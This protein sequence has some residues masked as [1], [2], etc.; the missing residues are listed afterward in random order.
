MNLQCIFLFTSNRYNE[1]KKWTDRAKLFCNGQLCVKK[2]FIPI[3]RN[4]YHW[5]CVCV[6]I[7]ENSIYLYDSL[8][9]H[10]EEEDNKIFKIIEDYFEYEYMKHCNSKRPNWERKNLSGTI[11][12]TNGRLFSAIKTILYCLYMKK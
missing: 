11:F 9:K 1:V 3:N 10:S 6:D 2:I 12:Q 8:C 5:L 7:T 4:G